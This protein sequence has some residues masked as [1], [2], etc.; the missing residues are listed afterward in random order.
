MMAGKKKS[1]RAIKL[2]QVSEIFTDACIAAL[3]C[4]A[5]LPANADHQRFASGIRTAARIYARDARASNLNER[6]AEIGA[7]YR[8]ARGRKYERVAALIANITPQ[9]RALLNKRGA[10]RTPVIKVPSDVA[11][12]DESMR[13]RA[14]ETVASL[15]RLG[16]VYGEGRKRK[17]GKR[18]RSWQPELHA[19]LTDP[20]PPKR[21]AERIFTMNLQLAWLEAVGKAPSLAANV[22]RLGPFARMVRECLVLA[23]AVSTDASVGGYI[24][25]LNRQRRQVEAEHEERRKREEKEAERRSGD[26][27]VNTQD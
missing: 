16:G 1:V 13:E 27:P 14:C 5:R 24:N 9:V 22:D 4:T 8:A 2:E 23:G 11:I 17:P 18:S 19:P 21:E 7:L 15:C 3:A 20:H 12:L 6:R 26:S 25:A 10:R